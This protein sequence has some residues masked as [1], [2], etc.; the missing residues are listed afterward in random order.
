MC[1]QATSLLSL[2]LKQ[3]AH[4]LKDVLKKKKKI[5][6]IAKLVYLNYKIVEYPKLDAN[7]RI[8]N[9]LWMNHMVN[10]EY[11]LIEIP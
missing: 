7:G 2:S 11:S 4:L 5:F 8:K 6:I 3:L 1:L 10:M 9:Q